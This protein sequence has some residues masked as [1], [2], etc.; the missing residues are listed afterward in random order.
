MTRSKPVVVDTCVWVPATT[1]ANSVEKRECDKLLRDKRVLTLGIIAT[2]VLRGYRTEGE[3]AYAGSRLRKLPRVDPTWEDWVHA[4]RLGRITAANGH[5]L[6]LADL[7]IAAVA[8]RLGAA[9]YTTDP[10]FDRIPDLDR[11]RP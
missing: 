11:F 7:L 9:V 10:H 1:R 5:D 6:P 2:E 3:A 8:L 4:G